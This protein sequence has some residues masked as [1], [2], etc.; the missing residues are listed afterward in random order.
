MSVYARILLRY[1]LGYLVLKNI[2]PQDIAELIENDPEIAAL[3]GGAL[4][5]AVEGAT[6]L[7]RRLGWKT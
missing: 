5:F 4:M 6:L 3:V 7:A 1:L 2:V